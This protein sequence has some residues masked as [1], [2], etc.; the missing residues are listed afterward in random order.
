LVVPGE[1]LVLK[2][3]LTLAIPVKVR[4]DKL[5]KERTSVLISRLG[6]LVHEG[7]KL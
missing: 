3:G 2:S 6:V 7:D 4:L 5:S 1:E